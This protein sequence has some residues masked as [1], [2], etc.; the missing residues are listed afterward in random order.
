MLFNRSVRYE[1]Q[2]QACA[3]D[4]RVRFETLSCNG[5]I[6]QWWTLE[7]NPVLTRMYENF[8]CLV[9]KA[10]TVGN[11]LGQAVQQAA[12]ELEGKPFAVMVREADWKDAMVE[13]NV[14]Q[15]VN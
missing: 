5:S 13:L 12:E 10:N 7:G 15:M 4:R 2:L 6:G 1:L 3:M 14:D 11:V 9:S 8:K